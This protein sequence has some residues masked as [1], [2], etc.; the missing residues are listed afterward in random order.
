MKLDPKK[1]VFNKPL[2]LSQAIQAYTILTEVI[3]E[4]DIE[5]KFLYVYIKNDFDLFVESLEDSEVKWIARKLGV[6][7]RDAVM[8]LM[9]YPYFWENL[10]DHLYNCRIN[11]YKRYSVFT[12]ADLVGDW[13]RTWEEYIG[14]SEEDAYEFYKK[15]LKIKKIVSILEMNDDEEEEDF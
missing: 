8:C 13:D 6:E 10:K 14:E 9:E 2:T 11:G 4:D 7:D 5:D 3:N 12:K 1:I 15:I